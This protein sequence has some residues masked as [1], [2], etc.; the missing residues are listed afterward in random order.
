MFKQ[1]TAVYRNVGLLTRAVRHWH[2]ST[3]EVNCNTHC[4]QPSSGAF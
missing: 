2:H 1:V 3:L 4:N